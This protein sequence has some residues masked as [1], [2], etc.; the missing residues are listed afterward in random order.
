MPIVLGS[1]AGEAFCSPGVDVTRESVATAG[2]P[3]GSVAL[4]MMWL[5]STG[6]GGALASP[7]LC[8]LVSS[9][10]LLGTAGWG[11]EPCCDVEQRKG[12]EWFR[13]RASLNLALNS[14]IYCCLIHVTLKCGENVFVIQKPHIKPALCE[15]TVSMCVC[16]GGGSGVHTWGG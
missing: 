6:W 4:E 1:R 11:G 8:P 3:V 13:Q 7:F 9:R 10:P 2:L 15:G 16:G 5:L 14:R 12:G